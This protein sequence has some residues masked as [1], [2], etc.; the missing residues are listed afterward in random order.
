MALSIRLRDTLEEFY[1]AS[2]QPGPEEFVLPDLDPW[3]FRARDWR[4]ILKGAGLGPIRMKDLRDTYASH[5]LSAGVQL[6]YVSKQLGHADVQV[7]ARHY[8]R[9]VGGDDY[10]EPMRLEEGE[11]PADF[12]S[13]LESHQSPTTWSG[14]LDGGRV[15]ARNRGAGDEDRTR[16]HLVGNQ[17]L[18]H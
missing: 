6:G 2:W 12:L 14:A 8:A 9:W 11:V 15:T 10:W 1:R 18:Y 13:R 7:T 5:L 3:N 4:R 17:E 16:D